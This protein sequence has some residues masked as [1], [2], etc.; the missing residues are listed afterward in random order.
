[1]EKWQTEYTKVLG[2]KYLNNILNFKDN[3]EK[4]TR[5]FSR[6]ILQTGGNDAI[7]ILKEYVSV[8]DMLRYSFGLY[9]SNVDYFGTQVLQ[10]NSVISTSLTIEYRIHDILFNKDLTLNSTRKE[11]EQP[12]FFYD[13][14]IKTL[15]TLKK[16]TTDAK[17]LKEIE[18]VLQEAIQY[19]KDAKKQKEN[20]NKRI[21]TFKKDVYY[22]GIVSKDENLI[23][24]F[25]G[26]LLDYVTND[27]IEGVRDTFFKKYHVKIED[28]TPKA[29]RVHCTKVGAFKITQNKI[30]DL[31]RL[32][33]LNEGGNVI[34][35]KAF[36]LFT[37]FVN[38]EE[39]TKTTEYKELLKKYIKIASKEMDETEGKKVDTLACCVMSNAEE[40]LQEMGWCDF[41]E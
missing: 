38:L 9:R 28:R 14:V 23:S 2:E 20:D 39:Q 35:K 6:D 7:E 15:E 13:Y 17:N 3:D 27:I 18:D 29:E 40:L 37:L 34:D 32:S 12:Y 21:Q 1:M 25:R 19:S 30:A 31:M 8:A 24:L 26:I 22:I 41:E 36:D 4:L 16:Q 33:L 11:L 10:V 5:D